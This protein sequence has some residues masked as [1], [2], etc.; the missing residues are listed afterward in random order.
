M[1]HTRHTRTARKGVTVAAE[2]PSAGTPRRRPELAADRRCP[3][4]W[5][6]NGETGAQQVAK[7]RCVLG[8]R[9]LQPHSYLVLIG[10]L[11]EV[12][13][14][15]AQVRGSTAISAAM[16]AKREAHLAHEQQG[17]LLQIE[18]A[19]SRAAGARPSVPAC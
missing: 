3:R 19:M 8:E 2:F 14:A 1:T 16:E 9:V 4:G 7:Q 6:G 5:C 17:C 13:C 11:W 15:I 12:S 18:I 10:I